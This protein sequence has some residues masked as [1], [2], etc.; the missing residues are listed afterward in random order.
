MMD[1][2]KHDMPCTVEV[3]HFMTRVYCIIVMYSCT[4]WENEVR[5]KEKIIRHGMEITEGRKGIRKRIV[6]SKVME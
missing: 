4:E 5:Q 2:N 3:C 6:E 1:Q